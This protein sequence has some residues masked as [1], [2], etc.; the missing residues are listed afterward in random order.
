M[1]LMKLRNYQHVQIKDMSGQGNAF[2]NSSILLPLAPW[3]LLL[4]PQP[5]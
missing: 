3:E 2:E 1:Q 5:M 4:D